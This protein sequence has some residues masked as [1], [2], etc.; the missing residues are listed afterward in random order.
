MWDV[1]VAMEESICC[2]K[3][4]ETDSKLQESGIGNIG[5]FDSKR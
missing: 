3:R 4:T 5:L 1:M 2:R